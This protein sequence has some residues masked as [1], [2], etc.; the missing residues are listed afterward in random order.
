MYCTA[1]LSPRKGRLRS[2]HDDDDHYDDLVVV[3]CKLQVHFDTERTSIF[4][5]L[6]LKNGLA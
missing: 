5:T 4:W 6:K 1:P 2:F 3:L